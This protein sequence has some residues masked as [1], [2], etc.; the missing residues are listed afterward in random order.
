MPDIP[1][2]CQNLSRF[3][4]LNWTALSGPGRV[5]PRKSAVKTFGAG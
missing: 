5:S 3:V 2:V 1:S 4:E